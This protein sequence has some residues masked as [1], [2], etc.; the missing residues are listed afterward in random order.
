MLYNKL[1]IVSII[2]HSPSQSSR[3]F[4]QFEML[5]SELLNEI[6]SKKPFP[7]S[8]VIPMQ[9]LSVGGALTNEVREVTVYF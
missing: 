6:A 2:Y 3:E 5:F 7:L 8:L 4:A 1:V 9:G